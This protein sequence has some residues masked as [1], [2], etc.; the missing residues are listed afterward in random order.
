MLSTSS[1]QRAEG[2]IRRALPAGQSPWEALDRYR[3]RGGRIG[4]QDWF[5][6]WRRIATETGTSPPRAVGPRGAA[7]SRSGA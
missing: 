5:R 4:W 2:A 3:A 6:L 1:R 7:L